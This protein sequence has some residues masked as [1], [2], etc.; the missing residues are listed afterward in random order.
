MERTFPNGERFDAKR[1]TLPGLAC[2]FLS[3]FLHLTLRRLE[4][5]LLSGVTAQEWLRQFVTVM[6][7]MVAGMFSR[8]AFCN[9]VV[10]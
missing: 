6:D 1:R 8:C 5:P 4:K 9:W 3:F 10:L 2:I 7:L